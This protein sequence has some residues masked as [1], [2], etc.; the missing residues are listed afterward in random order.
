[1]S[2]DLFGPLAAG[3]DLLAATSGAAWVQAMLDA[4]AALALASADVGVVTTGVADEIAAACATL[5]VDPAELGRA[6]RGGGN[7]VIPLVAVLRGSLAE[8][9]ASW[10]HWGATS[11]DILDTAAALVASRAGHMVGA[12]LDR[13]ADGCADLAERHRDTL[14][15]ARTLLQPALPTTFG[16]KAAGWLVGTLQ[17]RRQV[18]EATARLPASLG[19]AG[20]TLAAFGHDGPAVAARFATRLDLPAAL[21]PW[22][23]ARQPVAALGSALAV[24]TATAAKVTGDVALLMQAEVAE[25]SEPPGRGGSS[26]LP[27]KRNPIAATLV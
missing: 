9:G 18:A 12:H 2:G 17:A 10:V 16:A 20:G 8:P 7:P 22:H 26:T 4:E 11:Q 25:A 24:T 13:L 1:M 27:Q 3:D 14:T 23:T 21:V 15:V 5:E 19:G 6:G